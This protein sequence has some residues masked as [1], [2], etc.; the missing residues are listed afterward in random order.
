MIPPELVGAKGTAPEITPATKAKLPTRDEIEKYARLS[1]LEDFGRQ[2]H[3][4]LVVRKSSAVDVVK[5]EG[6]AAAY[7]SP[8]AYYKMSHNYSAWTNFFAQ[9][10]LYFFLG[11]TTICSAL[12]FYVGFHYNRLALIAGPAFM[13]MSYVMW[14]KIE[15]LWEQ[16]KYMITAQTIRDQRRGATATYNSMESLGN[17][18]D[19]QIVEMKVKK[20]AIIAG[21]SNSDNAP[22]AST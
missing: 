20:A 8:T 2:Q 5:A 3:Y 1:V 22:A 4:R 10:S 14:M 16:Q 6:A 15:E 9:G 21:G 17:R 19:D 13:V 12:S 18:L 7:K 11:T